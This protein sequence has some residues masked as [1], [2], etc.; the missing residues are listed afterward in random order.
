MEDYNRSAKRRA[1]EAA[2][3]KKSKQKNTR[4]RARTD[5]MKDTRPKQRPVDVSP[6]AE[7]DDQEFVKGF[8]HGG[9]VNGC[10]EAQVK[11]TKFSGTY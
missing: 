9:K 10:S 4:P 5:S 2:M 8:K 6:T 7:A 3:D 11:G 1:D